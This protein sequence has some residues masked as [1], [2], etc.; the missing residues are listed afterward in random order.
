MSRGLGHSR[1]LLFDTPK[2]WL[3]GNPACAPCTRIFPRMIASKGEVIL[4]TLVH[5]RK[6][7]SMLVCG[8]SAGPPL[9]VREKKRRSIPTT[10]LVRT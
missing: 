8:I 6:G 2:A 4:F 3:P 5:R 7:D 9:H 1:H 10:R